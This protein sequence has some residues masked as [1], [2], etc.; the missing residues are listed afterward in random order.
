MTTDIFVDNDVLYNHAGFN[1]PVPLVKL[2]PTTGAAEEFAR[3]APWSLES[4]NI[5]KQ[6]Y[7][8][9]LDEPNIAQK[10]LQL[11]LV[12]TKFF[13]ETL[14]VRQNVGI[15]RSTMQNTVLIHTLDGLLEDIENIRR[16]PGLP[17]NI[18]LQLEKARILLLQAKGRLIIEGAMIEE[19]NRHRAGNIEAITPT[20]TKWVV[21]AAVV[22]AIVVGG[23]VVFYCSGGLA[24]PALTAA[25]LKAMGIFAAKVA[26][27][28]AAGAAIG[29][30]VVKG[31]DWLKAYK[32][33]H[34]RLVLQAQEA[35]EESCAGLQETGLGDRLNTLEAEAAA[36]AMHRFQQMH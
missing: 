27:G 33:E 3:R 20:G 5:C 7:G 34:E 13:G 21:G 22:G 9:F 8:H 18:D 6:T 14:V 36:N 15:F 12:A 1:T 16:P 30:G 26:G 4:Y 28:A 17:T 23:I 29:Y 24:A 35:Y 32:H 31:C 11:S 10:A 25:S 2:S 19:F